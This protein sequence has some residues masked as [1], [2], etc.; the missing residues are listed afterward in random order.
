MK[1]AKYYSSGKAREKEVLV[2]SIIG[3]EGGSEA[4]SADKIFFQLGEDNDKFRS[5]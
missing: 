5:F 3:T 2:Y 4:S 1:T